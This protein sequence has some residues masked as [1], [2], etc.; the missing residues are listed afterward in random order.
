MCDLNMAPLFPSS[1]TLSDRSSPCVSL[2]ALFLSHSNDVGGRYF[3]EMLRARLK[4]IEGSSLYGEWSFDVFGGTEEEWYSIA[5]F[6]ET[7]QLTHPRVKWVVSLSLQS[8]SYLKASGTINSFGEY[9]SNLFI[10]LGRATVADPEDC[11]DKE[12]SLRRFLSNVSAFNVVGDYRERPLCPAG[13]F[14]YATNS[15]YVVA[16]LLMH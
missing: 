5:S 16:L 4:A 10:P 14:L 8:Y 11:S 9:L 13:W 12:S 15:P 3:A 1:A 6:V 2:R 7:Y